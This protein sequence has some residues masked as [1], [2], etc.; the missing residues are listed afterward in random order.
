MNK[1]ETRVLTDRIL[2][3]PMLF[4]AAI[5]RSERM[6]KTDLSHMQMMVLGEAYRA[7]ILNMTE[8]GGA[9]SVSNQQ[10]TRLVDD[11]V[12]KGLLQRESDPENRRVVLVRLTK[13]GNFRMESY[14]DAIAAVF[15]NE[16]TALPPA[17]TAALQK[18]VGDLCDILERLAKSA[19]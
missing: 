10:I 2:K 4:R 17:D 16:I 12:R 11:L 18:A 15:Y 5:W 8:L 9:V 6:P 13:E 1:R 19:T 7:K 3:L 14:F